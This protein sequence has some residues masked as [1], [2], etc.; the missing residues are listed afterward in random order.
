ML[1]WSNLK[2]LEGNQ[3][4]SFEE[5]CYTIAKRKYGDKGR[6]TSINDSGGGSGVEFY[7]TFPDGTQWG[8]Q[9][10]YFYE[11]NGR[12]IHGG[13]KTQ[14]KKSLQ[15][16]CEDHPNLERWFLCTPED[17]TPE[18]QSWFKDD[19]ATSI[20]DGE[21]VVPDEHDVELLHWGKS[22]FIS[23][24]SEEQCKGIRKYFFGQLELSH[25]WFERI[26][27][28]AL[29]SPAGERYTASLHTEPDIGMSAHRLLGDASFL[30]ELEQG[31]EDLKEG[32]RNFSEHIGDVKDGR[33][34]KID[35]NGE[36]KA[37]AGRDEISDLRTLLDRVSKQLT[38]SVARL[39]LGEFDRARSLENIERAIYDLKVAIDEYGQAVG[40][41]DVD[42][43]SYTGSAQ[44]R[45]GIDDEWDQEQ[46]SRRKARRILRKP[47]HD[48]SDFLRIAEKLLENL[49]ELEETVLHVLGDAA[50]GKTHL[51]FDLCKSHLES[52]L[53]A[54]LLLGQNVSGTQPLRRQLLDLMDVPSEY[55]WD[56]FISALDVAAKISGGRLPL[57]IDGLNEAVR[58][59]RLSEIWQNELSSLVTDLRKVQ[60]VVLITT[61]RRAYVDAIWPE[62]EPE[63]TVVTKGF[64][65]PEEAVR[66]YFDYYNI[67]ASLTGAP[68]DQFHHPIYLRIFC[69]AT[70]PDRNEVKEVY[71]GEQKLFSVFEDYIDKCNRSIARRLG[72]HPDT[73]LVRP[74]LNRLA[75]RLWEDEERRVALDAAIECIEGKPE[76]EIESWANSLTH[77]VESEGLIISRS[78]SDD[79]EEF[80]FTYDL[81]AGYFI[82]NYLID[83]F[84]DD[85]G[86]YL[87]REDVLTALYAEDFQ[88]RHPLHEDIS[89]CLAALLPEKRG[90]YLHDLLKSGK[91][92][93]DRMLDTFQ[94]ATK[95]VADFFEGFSWANRFEGA[96]RSV[97]S[98]VSRRTGDQREELLLSDSVEALFE[99]DPAY[100][101]PDAV[102]FVTRL[103]DHPENRSA[104]FN[105]FESTWLFSNHPLGADFIHER[106]QDLEMAERDLAWSEHIRMRRSDA[107]EVINSLKK[108]CLSCETF[109]EREETRLSL[110]AL[111][112]M[113]TLTTTIRPLRDR[114]TEALYW[115]GRRFPEDFFKLV[116]RSFRIDDPYV[117]ERMIA[118]AYGVGMARQYDFE[119]DTFVN[120]HLPY[121]SRFLYKSMFS[122]NAAC[123]TAHVLM[124][125]YARHLIDMANLHHPA[126][127]SNDELE[128]ARPP[129]E[130]GDI[131]EWGEAD[132]PKSTVSR[133]GPILMDFRNYTLGQLVPDRRNYDDEHEEYKKLIAKTYWR[134]YDLGWSMDRFGEIDRR[135]QRMQS[136]SRHNQAG[137]TDRYGKKYSWIAFF[138]LYGHRRDHDALDEWEERLADVDIDPSFPEPPPPLQLIDEDW[139]GAPDTKTK[140]W[141]ANGGE[142][143][144][145]P[146]LVVDELQQEEGP[147]VL[148][149]SFFDH[150]DA[151]RGRD[152]WFRVRTTL[153]ND[154]D[155]G[156]VMEQSEKITNRVHEVNAAPSRNYTFAGEVPWAD[157][158]PENSEIK[159]GE[160]H[161]RR[162]YSIERKEEVSSITFQVPESVSEDNESCERE[163]DNVEGSDEQVGLTELEFE[164]PTRREWK[165]ECKTYTRVLVP[166]WRNEWED[167][168]NEINQG[169]RGDV[170]A[171]QLTDALGLVS[172]PQT[173]DLYDP[174]GRRASV[175]THLESEHNEV[176]RSQ[177]FL[178]IRKD[179]LDR[180]LKKTDQELLIWVAGE[181]QYSVK[182]FSEKRRDDNA[183]EGPFR[184]TFSQ[185]RQYSKD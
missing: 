113:W 89:R 41:F 98:A 2:P 56:D 35:W 180:Y 168:H 84:G 140:E 170:P 92:F 160:V 104:L 44:S 151:G 138:E 118:A 20:H 55:S 176:K 122:P 3:H 147:W 47:N 45:E 135:I 132:K 68:L 50:T 42:N 14:I 154:E 29:E 72:Q 17:F 32:R 183:E 127:F 12:L 137:K 166:I 128:V 139:L 126:L 33:P 153:V 143:S 22:A 121:W 111:R 106:L 37:F 155:V 83:V 86:E 75:Q 177:R 171:R 15:R 103:F 172:Q 60:D 149:S 71:L 74:A 4:T 5:L 1:D 145:A 88:E 82:A 150:E 136:R 134:I 7:L 173:Y 117:R 57:I 120:E 179:L 156:E 185:V 87:N 110:M 70:N 101:S 61:C 169:A 8:W 48:A 182:T 157:T 36:N 162:T 184:E 9:S 40:E 34:P 142:P 27:D 124:R 96:F 85:F 109:S 95:Q 108:D 159:V 18:E 25:S 13:R 131:A 175:A 167:Y 23:H 146:F 105:R 133:V 164:I 158:F 94:H 39:R 49:R 67:K 125:D 62:E 107:E 53:P 181:R 80:L 116:K 52:G 178:F 21:Q 76:S 30:R 51:A 11:P 59:G 112:T 90:E 123:R 6:F 65:Q 81:M 161:N 43:L 100:I 129:Y 114:A 91:S 64:E 144:L 97:E 119:S 78:W 63:R 31:L 102:D 26:Y 28:R 99:I 16:S 69:E 148:L 141:I 73:N 115:Y 54:I 152:L 66:E 77:A 174:S 79:K 165:I 10:K 46:E 163:Y 38:H 130:G 58:D 24:L 93:L 19:L